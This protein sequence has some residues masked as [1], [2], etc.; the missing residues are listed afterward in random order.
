MEKVIIAEILGDGSPYLE[1]V[2]NSTILL[3]ETRSSKDKR[4]VIHTFDSRES[5]DRFCIGFRNEVI[6]KLEA[7]NR[8]LKRLL[9]EVTHSEERK[10]ATESLWIPIIRE[11]INDHWG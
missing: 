8:E 5:A 3:R 1:D 11:C 2:T 10:K 7:E 6:E 4:A 9:F